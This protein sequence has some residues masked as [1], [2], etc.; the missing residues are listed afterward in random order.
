M[1]VQSMPAALPGER[2]FSLIEQMQRIGASACIDYKDKKSMCSSMIH[3]G[4]FFDGTNNN[5]KRDQEN[6]KDPNKRSHSNVVVL[7]DTF[8]DAPDEGYYRFYVPG[9]GTPFDEIGERAETPDGK[10]MATGGD[11]RINW[12]MIQVLNAM[13]RSIFSDERLVPEAQVGADATTA[14]LHAG[15]TTGNRLEGKRGYFIGGTLGKINQLERLLASKATATP[16]RKLLQVNV[17]VFGF[18]RGA[19]QARAFCHFV[20]HIM[21]KGGPAGGYT[22]AGVPFRF[23]FLGLFDSVASVGL[24]DSSPFW[25]G[26]GGWANGTLDIVPGVERTVHLCAAH[27]IRINFPLSTGR[28]GEKQYPTNCIEKVYP[29]A[30]SDVGGGYDPGCQGKA[31]GSRTKLLSQMPLLDMYREAQRSMV[32]LLTITQLQKA[33]KG[34]QVVNDLK[35]DPHSE[36]LF[37]AYRGFTTHISGT[38][39][40]HLHGHVQLYWRWRLQHRGQMHKLPSYA[41]AVRQDQI[42]VWESDS[43]FSS[44]IAKALEME[45]AADRQA[46]ANPNGPDASRLDQ[47]QRDFL[48]V[49]KEYLQ[50]PS[51][52]MPTLVD[53]FFDQMLHDSHASFYMVGPVTDFDRKEKIAQI[54]RKVDLIAKH[55]EWLRTGN[56]TM[57][58]QTSYNE[59]RPLASLSDLERRIHEHQTLHQGQFPELTDKD[60]EQ[61]LAMEDLKTSAG[62]RLVTNKTRRE[63]GGHVRYRRVFDRS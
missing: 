4:I 42:D 45:Q 47:A 55:M 24:A 62:V 27:E 32:P 28:I 23:Q 50:P 20:H 15:L 34:D 18:S 41:K 53:A 12:A 49:R 1:S 30:H 52:R 44:D 54:Q 37:N 7:H 33:A 22:L 51:T 58:P 29:G 57:G 8:K 39:E 36:K 14:P 2:P 25:R 19:A 6:V 56:G 40:N 11:A 46:K 63:L 16:S 10:S 59:A 35:I 17:S 43:D 31:V 5:K 38:V 3:V 61:L 21:L 13:K 9:V 48:R 26:L 60:R